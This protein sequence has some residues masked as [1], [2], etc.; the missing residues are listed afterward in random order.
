VKRLA[1]VWGPSIAWAAFLFVMSSIPGQALPPLNGSFLGIDSDKLIHGGVYA[2][3]GALV[4][5]S[6]RRTWRIAPFRAALVAAAAAAL[7]GVTDEVHQIF[8]PRRSP[9]WHDA[10]AD[11]VGGLAG[12][13]LIS[14]ACVSFATR[15]PDR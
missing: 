6:V 5:R 1:W 11:A 14:A 3:L 15:R 4:W 8:T 9:D 7:Y 13:L 2:V 12:A 10:L